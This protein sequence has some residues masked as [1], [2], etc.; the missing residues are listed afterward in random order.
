MSP[1]RYFAAFAFSLSLLCS[2]ALSQRIEHLSIVNSSRVSEKQD[3]GLAIVEPMKCSP[4]GE[5]YVRFARGAPEAGVSIVST[6]GQ[7][8]RLTL[9]ALPELN[10]STYLDYAPGPRGSAY[11]L[12]AKRKTPRTEVEYRVVTLH[13]SRTSTFIKLDT[14]PELALRQ[15]A[16]LGSN[17]FVVS[18]YARTRDKGT[19]S[20]IA[21]FD[22]R[23]QFERRVPLAGDL[24]AKHLTRLGVISK[25]ANSTDAVADWL[26]VS[27]LQTADDGAVYLMRR[28]PEGP[29]F[30]ISPGAEV[31]KISL[32]APEKTATLSSVKV[33]HGTIAAEYYLAT[34]SPEKTRVHYITLTDIR[35]GRIQ[36]KIRYEGS[37]MTGL[38]L[39]CYS[40][41]GF[42]FLSQDSEGYLQI[43]T[44]I[45][46]E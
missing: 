4:E 18:G 3:I 10:G 43:V 11:L 42:E 26:E 1:P 45:A 27:S 31:R 8:H 17:A 44:A 21:I 6:D 25:N 15:I 38:G 16:T 36:R 29:V 34:S 5:L 7:V 14:P 37:R 46:A 22:D 32:K 35:S 40:E 41:T 24:D 20:F 19:Q 30:L 2:Y 39:A 13:E 23:G 12:V 9:S 28:S 33:N